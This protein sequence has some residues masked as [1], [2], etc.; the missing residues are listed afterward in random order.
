MFL[1][2]SSIAYN[3]L[4]DLFAVNALANALDVPFSA[5]LF[6]VTGLEITIVC[7]GVA[8]MEKI[9]YLVT[10]VMFVIVIFLIIGAAGLPAAPAPQDSSGVPVP[11]VLVAI[12]LGLALTISRS[13]QASD[14]SRTLP[15]TISPRKVFAGVFLGITALLLLG[16]LGAWTST[17]AALDNPMV[18]LDRCLVGAGRQPLR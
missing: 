15:A 5:A 14:V 11:Q 6:A 16:G 1:I 2:L 18:A 3:C 9:G 4:H 13:V 12:M 10:G 8:L 7:I 17:S